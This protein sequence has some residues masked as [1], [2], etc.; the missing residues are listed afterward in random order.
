MR[1]RIGAVVAAIGLWVGS[2]SAVWAAQR[3][4]IDEAHTT[5]GFSI[6]HLVINRVHGNFRQLSGAIVYDEADITKSSVEVVIK[7]AGIDTG[8]DKR[9]GHLRSPDFF[10]ADKY[11]EI[12]FRSSRIERQGEGYLCTGTLTMHGVSKE[13][14]I[15]FAITGTVR[16]P[17]GKTR[18]GAEAA[19]TLNRQDYGIVYNKTLESGGM[20]LGNDVKIELNV[21]AV[22]EQPAAAAQ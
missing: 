10:D 4:A 12:V 16:D 13:I 6:P 1:Y 17:W 11:P 5:V 15:P 20:L 18:L 2:A 3:Y 9:D 8:N 22:Q 14:Q 21:E 19:L 7:A